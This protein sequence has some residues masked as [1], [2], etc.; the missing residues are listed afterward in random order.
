MHRDEHHHDRVL[1]EIEGE[2]VL[3]LPHQPLLLQPTIRT[4]NFDSTSS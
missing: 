2:F 3:L 4:E 1:H